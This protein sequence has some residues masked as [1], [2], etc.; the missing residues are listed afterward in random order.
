MSRVIVSVG[1]ARNICQVHP[2]LRHQVVEVR[3]DG[4]GSG[5]TTSWTGSR[6]RRSTS[7]PSRMAA[8]P[9]TCRSRT[10]WV[11][12]RGRPTSSTASPGLA[13]P[14]AADR[15]RRD[16]GHEGHRVPKRADAG[17]VRV[18]PNPV[19]GGG[20]ELA[21]SAWSTT[22]PGSRRNGSAPREVVEDQHAAIRDEARR[23]RDRGPPAW[24]PSLYRSAT[25]QP[26]VK[27]YTSTPASANSTSKRQEAIG[28]GWRINWYVRWSAA[29][30]R[31]SGF[32]STP[33]APAAS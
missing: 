30:P 14:S 15:H 13:W 22:P 4:G 18:R 27:Q 9:P 31:P 25:S 23:K 7:P 32:T 17:G 24:R 10:C 12:R 5:S 6:P 11:A 16:E 8:T 29:S 2:L 28:P 3:H 19:C 33:Y 21:P 20:R 26:N 1:N